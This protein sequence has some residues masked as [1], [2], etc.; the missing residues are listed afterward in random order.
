MYPVQTRTTVRTSYSAVGGWSL[1]K[2]IISIYMGNPDN[3]N[4]AE[5]TLR[6]VLNLAYS[7]DCCHVVPGITDDAALGQ[8]YVENDF[9][10][11]LANVPDS[12]CKYSG[13]AWT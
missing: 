3:S 4:H 7:V 6:R 8:F 9:R 13:K 5:L 11:D 2:K 1:D 10:P 12:R